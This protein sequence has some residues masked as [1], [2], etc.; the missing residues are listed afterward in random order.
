MTMPGFVIGARSV[1]LSN[2]KDWEVVGGNPARFI[3]KR[4]IEH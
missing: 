4:I 2:I 3:K 1:V